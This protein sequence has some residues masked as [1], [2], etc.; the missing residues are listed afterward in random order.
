MPANKL[1]SIT[2]LAPAPNNYISRFY[3][4]RG[5]DNEYEL[6]NSATAPVKAGNYKVR[7]TLPENG[8]YVI[9]TD[10]GNVY[11]TE[12]SFNVDKKLITGLMWSKNSGLS[13]EAGQPELEVNTIEGYLSQLMVVNSFQRRLGDDIENI[14]FNGQGNN[15]YTYGEIKKLTVNIYN[16][17]DYYIIIELNSN[18]ANNYSWGEDIV[19]V[20]LVFSVAA[21]GVSIEN[22]FIA[23]WT[24]GSRESEPETRLSIQVRRSFRHS[25]GDAVAYA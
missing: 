12:F 7:V 3:T 11:E 8:D 22:L 6:K 14:E 18:A 19:N 20:T 21:N 13:F 23:D 2:A 9:V 16:I 17:G 4:G 15:S 5:F 24:Y 25:G 1:P 10:G